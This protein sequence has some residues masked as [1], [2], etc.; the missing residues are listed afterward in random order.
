MA[1]SVKINVDV[2]TNITGQ[3]D[4]KKLQESLNALNSANASRAKSEKAASAAKQRSIIQIAEE[5][6]A[7]NKKRQIQLDAYA[8]SIESYKKEASSLTNITRLSQQK[9]AIEL[10]A[11]KQEKS[12]ADETQKAQKYAYKFT[13]IE[14]KMGVDGAKAR[15]KAEKEA[16]A[17]RAKAEKEAAATKAK[18]EKEAAREAEKA[19]KAEIKA[20]K[21][22]AKEAEKA[23]KAKIKAE[24]EAAKESEKTIKAEIKANNEK[25]KQEQKLNKL[26]EQRLDSTASYASS[27]VQKTQGS[28]S[29]IKDI[30]LGTLAGIGLDDMFGNI[31]EQLSTATS[32]ASSIVESE[33]L[34][35]A[36]YNEGA[37]ALLNWADANSEAYGLANASAK[38]YLSFLTGVLNNTD[39]SSDKLGSMAQNYTRLVGDMASAYNTEIDDAFQAIRSGIAGNTL[40]MQRY[41]IVLSVTNLQQYL[42]SKGIETTYRSLDAASKQYVRYAYIMEHTSEIQGDYARTFDSFANSVKTLKNEWNNFL[43]LVGQYAIPVLMPIINAL[44]TA[45]AYA[46]AILKYLA[47]IYG[48]E[49]Y[50]TIAVDYSYQQVENIEDAVDSQEEL[51]AEVNNTNKA[52]KSGVKLLDLY[53]LDFSDASDASSASSAGT[54]PEKIPVSAQL[55]DLANIDYNVPESILPEIDVDMNKV[56]S[57]GDTI[58]GI[59]DNV[60]WLVGKT[61]NT[62]TNFLEEPWYKK[63]LDVAL[64]GIS[65]IVLKWIKDKVPTWLATGFSTASSKIPTNVKSLMA[66]IGGSV[67]LGISSWNLGEAFAKGDLFSGITSA[68]GA[69]VGGGLLLTKGGL[70]S[71][72]FAEAANS[73]MML[74]GVLGKTAAAA[75]GLF[76]AFIVGTAVAAIANISAM[77]TKFS[78]VRKD[79]EEIA[80]GSVSL[81]SIFASSELST[82]LQNFIDKTD[83]AAKSFESVKSSAEDALTGVSAVLDESL[84]LPEEQTTVQYV[85]GKC[86]ALNDEYKTYIETTAKPVSEAFVNS[87]TGPGGILEGSEAVGASLKQTLNT[88]LDM[89]A[90]DL[91]GATAQLNELLSKDNRTAEDEARIEFLRNKISSLTDQT[92]TVASDIESQFADADLTTLTDVYAK[93]NELKDDYFSSLDAQARDFQ[94]QIDLANI[95]LSSEGATEEEKAKAK[96]AVNFYTEL[97]NSIEL[98]K[99]SIGSEISKQ[100]EELEQKVLNEA[101]ERLYKVAGQ[102]VLDLDLKPGESAEDVKAAADDILEESGKTLEGQLHEWGFSEEDL[103]G[104]TQFEK[105]QMLVQTLVLQRQLAYGGI[106]SLNYGSNTTYVKDTVKNALAGFYGELGANVEFTDYGVDVSLPGTI[107]QRLGFEVSEPSAAEIKANQDSLVAAMTKINKPAAESA[108]KTV[109]DDVA[110]AAAEST[111]SEE[112]TQKVQEAATE[113]MTNAL[114]NVETP[115]EAKEKGSD[116][117]TSLAS[118]LTSGFKSVTSE[119]SDFMTSADKLKSVLSGISSDFDTSF[120]SAVNN[121]AGYINSLVNG[122]KQQLNGLNLPEGELTVAQLYNSLKDSN[123]KIPMLANGGVIPAN[124]PFL[125]VLGDQKS[126][127]NVEAPVTVIQEAVRNV[128]NDPGTSDNI[129]VKVYIGDREIR[130]FVIDTVTANN[131]V[132]G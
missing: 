30:A 94:K 44:R 45:I 60:E 54:T 20:E 129:E 64:A 42:Q 23:S 107:S 46:G 57:I 68:I 36:T 97:L 3:D 51:T 127:V 85:T 11:A 25:I 70:Y 122:L 62:I 88:M 126:G 26:S 35:R 123:F 39:I 37:T 48:W 115:E 2:V 4:V 21:E 90:Q 105:Q 52:L 5:I 7:E 87:L 100:T 110:N 15:A 16:A 131:L 84:T 93:A 67:L 32:N 117:A 130:D 96:D 99:R 102:I 24:K 86:K 121:V 56:K 19:N 43:S 128:V 120:K 22:A 125:A 6:A 14:V 124:N 95:T 77:V 58:S 119:G 49:Q 98:Q 76:S 112:N 78:E 111:K 118:G 73:G 101:D 47:E 132:V 61:K 34:L 71:S 91:S 10:A 66:K 109:G 1:N 12:L 9:A 81:T 80:T 113:M 41:G 38:Q 59:I 65:L 75:T 8:A 72:I 92:A 69:A 33:N 83:G 114:S 79:V 13:E 40:A 55:E 18:A 82:G 28:F 116:I 50:T 31:G 108:G 106:D 53:S 74:T 103:E 104:K 63:A 29:R 89:Q 17:A 27:L